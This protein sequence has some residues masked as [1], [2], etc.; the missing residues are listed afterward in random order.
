VFGD[1]GFIMRRRQWRG[2]S[3]DGMVNRC[4]I[5]YEQE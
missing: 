3:G 2:V 1:L 5:L 4:V